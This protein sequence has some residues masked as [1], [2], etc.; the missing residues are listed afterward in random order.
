MQ[1]NSTMQAAPLPEQIEALRSEIDRLDDALLELVEQ[2]LAASLAIAALKQA[3]GRVYLNMRPRREQAVI[4]RL[5][6][7]ARNAPPEVIAQ[8]W[9]T[10]MSHSLQAQ[11]RTELV[12]C[13][14]GDRAALLQ[15]VRTRFGDAAPIRWVADCSQAL[16][17]ARTSESVAVIAP[18]LFDCAQVD[19][20]IFVFDTLRDRE[21]NTVAIAAGRVAPE[22]A[23]DLKA[24]VAA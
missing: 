11:V 23:I 4:E 5:V 15:Q 10:V 6:K 1:N 20:P 16:E 9:R 14:S 13:S 3:E 2:R 18:D 17:A 8:I 7:R 22:D 24:L 19:A 12:L 21:G